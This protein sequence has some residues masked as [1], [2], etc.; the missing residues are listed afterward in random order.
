MHLDLGNISVHFE[1]LG[2]GTP[3]VILP[4]FSLNLQVMKA[5]LEPVFEKEPSWYRVYVDPPGMG[6]TKGADW[7]KGSDQMLE[8][9]LRLI[10]HLIPDKPFVLIGESYGGYLA[11][12]VLYKRFERVLGMALI[13]PL[14]NPDPA[15][16]NV[17]AHK[18]LYREASF[19]NALND[20][21]RESFEA[22][23][24]VQDESHWNHYRNVLVPANS[25]AD[26]VFLQKIKQRYAFSF[27]VDQL[28]EPF[29]RPVLL[30]AGRQDSVTGYQDAWSI[31][32]NYSR[33]TFAVLDRAG[34]DLTFEQAGL[35]EALV[36]E[37]LRRV[38]E[39]NPRVT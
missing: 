31:L 11:R 34:H 20:P 21:E 38:Q 12:G 2:F 4:P 17:P 26:L 1:S 37:W 22:Y 14:I 5:C 7:I 33:A 3:V 18:V 10:D 8:A 28:P 39:G 25:Q 27:E 30:L 23:A 29:E 36:A 35:F 19:L 9:I 13:C 15:K 24:V 16:R 32:G 6:G